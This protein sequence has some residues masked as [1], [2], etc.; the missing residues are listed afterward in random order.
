[1]RSTRGALTGLDEAAGGRRESVLGRSGVPFTFSQLPSKVDSVG[2]SVL[3]G[4]GINDA[5]WR[6]LSLL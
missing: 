2:I 1:M 4:E 5:V 6:I 3:K